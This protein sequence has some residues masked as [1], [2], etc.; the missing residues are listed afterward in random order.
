VVKYSGAGTDELD[1][2]FLAAGNSAIANNLLLGSEQGVF[3][4]PYWNTNAFSETPPVNLGRLDNT[5]NQPV[6]KPEEGKAWDTGNIDIRV[7]GSFD[8][9][10]TAHYFAGL[11]ANGGLAHHN[12]PMSDEEGDSAELDFSGDT[13]L[14]VK[15]YNNGHV[16]VTQGLGILG[17]KTDGK[18]DRDNDI[19]LSEFAQDKREMMEGS[20]EQLDFKKAG[21]TTF[22]DD[23]WV[24]DIFVYGDDIILWIEGNGIY[25]RT[26]TTGEPRP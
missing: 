11:G 6:I 18:P 20:K 13:I 10:G 14:A 24:R 15:P 5:K 7:V 2:V 16:L 26:K 3:E 21:G 25:L 12:G 8:N 19:K 22:S 17:V 1:V 9:G 4:I 23:Q